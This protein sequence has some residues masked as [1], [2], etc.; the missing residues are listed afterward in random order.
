MKMERKQETSPTRR[1]EGGIYVD[2]TNSVYVFWQV[3]IPSDSRCSK[4]YS[5][6]SLRSFSPALPQKAALFGSFILLL[7]NLLGEQVRSHHF[8]RKSHLRLEAEETE[9]PSS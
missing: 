8:E 6:P 5:L 9:A 2:K 7:T 1:N 3:V 4:R